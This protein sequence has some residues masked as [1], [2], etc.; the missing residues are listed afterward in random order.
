[1]LYYKKGSEKIY[2]IFISIMIGLVTVSAVFPLIYVIGMS[3]TSQ[4]ELIQRNYFV[5]LPLKPTLIAY[6]RI[7]LSPVIPQA[8]LVSIERT[9]I[10][11]ILTLAFT[12]TGAYVLSVKDLPGRKAF[13]MMILVTILFGGG[14]IPSYFVVKSAGLINSLWSMIIPIMV[15]SFGLLVFK[16][17]IENLPREIYES[18]EVDGAGELSKLIFIVFPLSAPALAA[19]G[20]F[21]AVGHWNSWFDALIYVNGNMSLYPLQLVIRNLLL[22]GIGGDMNDFQNILTDS[23][24]QV[25]PEAIKMA[26]VVIGVV[27]ILCVYPFLQK[28]FM[29]GVYMGSVKG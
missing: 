28:Y 23:Q 27:P 18:V 7:L 4:N 19:I 5:I 24:L 3:L 25:S 2:Q 9:V 26:A 1:M 13:L 17:F 29:H 20:M 10:G 22:A 16:V 15:D 8:F 14:L 6:S 21:N 11:T 12:F